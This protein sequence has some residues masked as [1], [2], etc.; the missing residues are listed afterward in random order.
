MRSDLRALAGRPVIIGAGVAGLMVALR[1]APEPVVLLSKG[2]PGT[3]SSSA[4]AQGGIAASLGDDDDPE[5]HLADTLAAGDGLC[6]DAIA[7]RITRAAPSAIRDLVRL[8]VRFDRRAGG[9]LALGLEAAHSRRRIVHAAGDGTGRE[10]VRALVEAVRRAPSIVV[11]EGF[12]A[13]RLRV[14][15]GTVVG[16]LAA[17]RG[18]TASFETTRVVIATGG[19]GG[20][21]AQSTNPNGCFGQGLAL[22]ARAGAALA[23]LEFIQFHPTALA[24]RLRPA[25]LIS[26][27]VRGEGAV[28]VDETGR[29]FLV[30]EPGA[31]LAPRDAVARAV[32][33]RLAEGHQ[34]FL[35]ARRNP[36]ARFDVRFPAIAAACR[37]AGLDPVTQLI[38]I[39][40]A[41]HYHMGG[42]AVDAAGHGS[43]PGLW[44]CGEAACTGLHGANRLA[45][46]SLIEAAVC[47]SWVAESVSGA[48]ASAGR[49]RRPPETSLPLTPDASRVRNILSRGVGVLRDEAGLR[50]TIRALLPLACDGGPVSDPA[51]IGLMI[52][53]A[54]WR[55]QESRGAHWRTD[56]PERGAA[57]RSSLRLEEALAAART[58]DGGCIPIARSA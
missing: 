9:A 44:A 36:G 43:V 29:R 33:R 15:D 38:P 57:Q 3:G 42:V 13:R 54:A 6:D 18:G 21:F 48:V 26:E 56:F 41:V 50:S 45:S 2:P 24:G 30:D 27:A 22:A 53:V 14:E 46:N 32:W 7:K 1:L 35:D 47:A 31:E 55:R 28:L 11:L 12:E 58:L 10:L 5:L 16:V 34:V 39:R 4:F 17:G 19:I 37:A 8:G 51:L 25:P 23:D 52:A 20:L 40:P 49:R